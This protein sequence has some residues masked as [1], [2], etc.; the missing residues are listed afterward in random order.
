MK[1]LFSEPEKPKM[2]VEQAFDVNAAVRRGVHHI[3]L[4]DRPEVFEDEKPLRAVP[5]RAVSNVIIASSSHLTDRSESRS[6]I[7]RSER[8]RVVMD[9]G[10]QASMESRSRPP[11][12]DQ[13][14][15]VFKPDI[16][17]PFM[18]L[19]GSF[20]DGIGTLAIHWATRTTMVLLRSCTDDDYVADDGEDCRSNYDEQRTEE[21]HRLWRKRSLE[22]PDVASR[23]QVKVDG[24]SGD[25]LETKRYL[26]A[27][28]VDQSPSGRLLIRCIEER[29]ADDSDSSKCS[30]LLVARWTIA[31]CVAFAPGHGVQALVDW[32]GRW[33]IFTGGK[34]QAGPAIA[35]EGVREGDFRR[36]L[37]KTTYD[38]EAS[39]C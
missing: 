11:V 32:P 19:T 20:R 38:E 35:G 26:D 21:A 10:L 25:H 7:D 30:K 39:W 13:H 3:P 14:C 29:S 5:V 31:T 16:P 9:L 33:R 34:G 37:C 36:D 27:G 28:A 8:L 4:A 24:Y 12:Q 17:T 23:T 18:D 15:S 22:E 2:W 6:G 1:S